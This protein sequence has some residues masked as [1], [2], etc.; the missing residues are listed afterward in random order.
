M[1]LHNDMYLAAATCSGVGEGGGGTSSAEV[2]VQTKRD[3][4]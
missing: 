1:E 2:P 3:E 4:W